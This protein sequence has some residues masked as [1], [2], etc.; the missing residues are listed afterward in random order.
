MRACRAAGGGVRR[1]APNIGDNT[2]L[3]HKHT[4]AYDRVAE[5]TRS[6]V[7]EWDEGFLDCERVLPNFYGFKRR[8]GSVVCAS[9]SVRW[10]HSKSC[11]TV[12]TIGKLRQEESCLRGKREME[13]WRLL[14]AQHLRHNIILLKGIGILRALILLEVCVKRF[15]LNLC[16]FWL[17]KDSIFCLL[18]NP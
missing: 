10:T 9:N 4:I 11:F 8:G 3:T 12:A 5:S 14:I 13:M 17:K 16:E 1:R 15:F 7:K 2:S 6:T 18:T